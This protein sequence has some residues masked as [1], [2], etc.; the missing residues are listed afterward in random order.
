VE[1]SIPR[2]LSPPPSVN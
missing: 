2:I 1:D